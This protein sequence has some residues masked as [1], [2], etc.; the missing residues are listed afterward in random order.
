MSMAEYGA[1]NKLIDFYLTHERPFN[2]ELAERVCRIDDAADKL[3]LQRI[4]DRHYVLGE[5]GFYRSEWCE[6]EIR[7][8][9]KKRAGI[10][11]VRNKG[12]HHIHRAAV[13]ARDCYKCVYCGSENERLQLDHVVPRSRGGSDDR[14]NLVAACRRCNMSKGTKLLS[15]WTRRPA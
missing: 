2:R 8:A 4:L 1:Y 10:E 12:A 9:A 14:E 7:K 3:V 13:L 11:S 6:D 5:D 15:E